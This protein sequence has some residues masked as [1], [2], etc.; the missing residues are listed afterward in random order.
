[1][2]SYFIVVHLNLFFVFCF[3]FFFFLQNWFSCLFLIRLRNEN[4]L[5]KGIELK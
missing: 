3:L 4:V 5:Y 2:I 1:M